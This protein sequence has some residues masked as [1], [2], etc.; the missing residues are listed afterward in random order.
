MTSESK[1]C[2]I[3][4]D[5]L[6][7]FGRINSCEH[8]FHFRCIRKWSKLSNRCPTCRL[9]FSEIR[10][11]K[12]GKI[13]KKV[14]VSEAFIEDS[15]EDEEFIAGCFVC[16]GDPQGTMVDCEGYFGCQNIAHFDCLNKSE[17]DFWVCNEC[18]L[19]LSEDSLNEEA[20]NNSLECLNCMICKKS[21]ATE[22]QPCKG[23]FGCV[24]IIHPA[25][26]S[27]LN[28]DWTCPDCEMSADEV[29]INSD[30]DEPSL[31]SPKKSLSSDKNN[32]LIVISS[33]SE[34]DLIEIEDKFGV[35]LIRQSKQ[36]PLQ[37]PRNRRLNTSLCV[38]FSEIC[39]LPQKR[40][41]PDVENE[42]GVLIRE[43]VRSEMENLG[44]LKF[45]V[46]KVCRV[47]AKQ[48]MQDGGD[49]GNKDRIRKVTQEYM[50]R[51][52]DKV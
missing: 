8:D 28:Q 37:A 49:L 24:N 31:Y 44:G 19:D 50:A 45:G 16:G 42:T 26:N 52:L 1:Q 34:S 18:S 3:C 48:I 35:Q 22:A 20:S 39:E 27:S 13:A 7:T 5:K 2:S 30:S 38:S 15:S 36:L 17:I 43:W 9:S 25:C 32:D 41:C 46:G 12:N 4:L 14:K 29:L 10:H 11:L 6:L 47:V 40:I 51:I 23:F 21:V 33:D